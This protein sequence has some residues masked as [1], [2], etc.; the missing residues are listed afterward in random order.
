MLKL[1]KDKIITKLDYEV[2]NLI[3]EL[4][5]FSQINSTNDYLLND[6]THHSKNLVCITDQQTAGYGRR[7]N[8]W[9]SPD[10]SNIYLSVRWYFSEEPS[11]ISALSLSV[12]IKIIEALQSLG[13][14]GIQIKWPN[15]LF[16]NNKKLGGILIER[17]LI[18]K[19]SQVVIGVGINCNMVSDE[20]TNNNIK[21]NW[22]NLS[23]CKKSDE[24]KEINR[25]LIISQILN[26]L[27]P[28]LDNYHL[29]GFISMQDKWQKL[30][31]LYNKE[32][33]TSTNITGITDGVDD[34]GA[35]LVKTPTG[36]KTIYADDINIQR[37]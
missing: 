9:V 8:N 37:F 33:K 31:F 22:I 2:K 6:K 17:K 21:Q 15:D 13:F 7:G 18:Q 32:I 24:I 25:N 16:Y 28:M 26:R 10:K 14:S 27:I 30:D 5:V 23:Q 36:I 11:C 4:Q 20:N 35:L 12:A 1:A 29:Q 19:N 3:D 34:S